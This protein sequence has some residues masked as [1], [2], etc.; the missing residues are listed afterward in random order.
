MLVGLLGVWEWG[1][2]SGSEGRVTYG[3]NY[4]FDE[5][6]VR[7]EREEGGYSCCPGRCEFSRRPRLS[8][9]H[10]PFHPYVSY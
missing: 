2:W 8:Q 5:C 7:R 4:E 10:Q 6:V 1:R 3:A 9:S